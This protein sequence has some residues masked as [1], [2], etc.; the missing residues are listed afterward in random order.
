[1]RPPNKNRTN[2]ERSPATRAPL[3]LLALA[4]FPALALLGAGRGPAAANRPVD[5]TGT[6]LFL[7]L[8][9]NDGGVEALAFYMHST[10]GSVDQNMF[11]H[12]EVRNTS[13]ATIHYGVLAAHTD[14]GV[15]ADS[16]HDPLT[17]GED[18][19][20]DDHINFPQPGTYQVYLGLCYASHAD[21]ISGLAP[22]ERLSDNVQVIITP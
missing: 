6:P 9:R 8:A 17:P 7:P 13:D 21:C 19:K 1:M 16:W 5:V 11:F 10:T 20:W 15:T 18:L 4:L 3:C 14:Q 12:F 2:G 22:W